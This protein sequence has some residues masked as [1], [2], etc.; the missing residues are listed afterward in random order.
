M[1]IPDFLAKLEGVK[2]NGDSQWMAKCPAHDDKT[3]S[4]SI[5]FKD[6]R[7]LIN[8]KAG[9][10][11]ATILKRLNLKKSD[12]FT[13]NKLDEQTIKSVYVYYDE[14]GNEVCEKVRLEPKAFYVRRKGPNGYI[15]NIKGVKIVPYRYREVLKAKKQNETIYLCEGEKDA[16][17]LVTLG[18]CGTSLFGGA[19]SAKTLPWYP[20]YDTAFTDADV[21]I[22]PDKNPPDA[23][24]LRVGIEHA[25][26]VYKKLFGICNSVSIIDPAPFREPKGDITEWIEDGNSLEG[27]DYFK[28]VDEQ[29]FRYLGFGGLDYFFLDKN[30]QVVK[31]NSCQ[32]TKANLF[33]LAPIHYW[34]AK[35]PNGRGGIALDYAASDIINRCHDAGF[36]STDRVRGRGAWMDNRRLV[37]HLG[38]KLYVDGKKQSLL[39]EKSNFIYPVR[40][41]ISLTEQPLNIIE[42]RNFAKLVCELNWSNKIYGKMLVGWIVLAPISGLLKWRPHIWLSGPKESGKTWILTNIVK[43]AVGV[44]SLFVQSS[45]TEAGIR[46][47]LGQDAIAVIFDEAEIDS[48]K[49]QNSMDKVLE[50]IR[51]ASSSSET[52]S[53]VRGTPNGTALQ[54]KIR[55]M[56]C[57]ASIGIGINR[58]A[59]ESRITVLTLEPS[60]PTEFAG[61]LDSYEMNCPIYLDQKLI[62]RTL[63]N[64][65]SIL[66]TISSFTGYVA[67][68]T[69]NQ[70]LGEQLGTLLAGWYSTQSP[71]EVP[72]ENVHKIFEEYKIDLNVF[73]KFKG[74]DDEYDLLRHIL[75]QKFVAHVEGVNRKISVMECLNKWGPSNEYDELLKE[76]GLVVVLNKSGKSYF[77]VAAAHSEVAKMLHKTRWSRNWCSILLRI[78]GAEYKTIR[79]VKGN[80]AT[81]KGTCIPLNAVI[82][83][84]IF[85]QAWSNLLD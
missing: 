23:V 10:E 56:F 52:A 84:N 74:T 40:P 9:C 17:T 59:D 60:T 36:Y 32:L 1:N 55:S 41:E 18:Y 62:V 48:A 46:Q 31:L 80:R 39:F 44:M 53:L 11:Y 43:Y 50:L 21:I 85:G 69:G 28:I 57:L 12:L 68:L 24:G 83:E 13:R 79:L 63:T 78:P 22:I 26:K 4:L 77:C 66:N 16:E 54:Y 58:A 72:P 30:H 25:M 5:G 2:Q 75:E 67:R 33:A 15:N 71:D 29:P 61:Y 51:Q 76:N 70:R 73:T 19:S 27:L 20:S 81:Y 8:C 37:V 65:R 34:A 3:P 35:Y 47:L 7:I 42:S 38:D 82:D 64:A 6:G 14:N 49:S 45:T